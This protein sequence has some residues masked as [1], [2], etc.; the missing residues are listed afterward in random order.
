[1]KVSCIFANFAC[2]TDE[3][4][5]GDFYEEGLCDKSVHAHTFC[6][7][8]DMSLCIYC[9]VDCGGVRQVFRVRNMHDVCERMFCPRCVSDPRK[10]ALFECKEPGGCTFLNAK[11]PYPAEDG[12]KKNA[13]PCSLYCNECALSCSECQLRLCERSRQK[14]G[15][16]KHGCQCVLDSCRKHGCKTCYIKCYACSALVSPSCA[17]ATGQLGQWSC[18]KQHSK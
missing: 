7:G 6:E 13:E 10:I 9:G 18:G 11:V 2:T 14:A 5:L 16:R 17:V 4:P 15:W 8:C 1:M 12:E 3:K